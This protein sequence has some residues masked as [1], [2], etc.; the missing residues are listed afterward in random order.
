MP[1]VRPYGPFFNYPD[2]E[3][4]A[5]YWT[6]QGHQATIVG[7]TDGQWFVNVVWMRDA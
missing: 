6:S 1:V 3:L 4:T 7:P 5:R 2:A